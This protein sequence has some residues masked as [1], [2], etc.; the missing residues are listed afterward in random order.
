M[1]KDSNVQEIKKHYGGKIGEIKLRNIR[2]EKSIKVNV[3]EAFPRIFSSLLRDFIPL[4]E[5]VEN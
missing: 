2:E 1:S 4:F 3:I 5:L